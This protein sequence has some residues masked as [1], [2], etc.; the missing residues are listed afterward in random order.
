M[1]NYRIC[2]KHRREFELYY[3]DSH[4]MLMMMRDLQSCYTTHER[5]ENNSTYS[6]LFY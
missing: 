1:D 5:R 4:N 6:L 3:L 2:G